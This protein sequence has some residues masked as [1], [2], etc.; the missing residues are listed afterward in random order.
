MNIPAP[1]R[2][3]A[4]RVL[5]SGSARYCNICGRSWRRFLPAGVAARD[6]ARCPGCNSLERH[7]LVW[8]FFERR[9]NLFDRRPKRVLHIAPESCFLPQLRKALGSNYVTADLFDP[10]ADHQWDVT[11]VPQPNESFDVIYCS[12][13]LEHVLEDRKAM[14]E[15]HRLLKPDGWAVINVPVTEESTFEDPSVTDPEERLRLFGQKD[16]VRRYGR[17]YL[18]RLHA[19]GFKVEIV[20]PSEIFSA[21]DI[22]R[23]AVQIETAGDVYHCTK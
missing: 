19:A 18:D 5:L 12:H 11:A 2:R 13:V 21:P 6:D 8:A 17:D 22:V 14:A 23:L 16:H 9:T 20:S 10:T 15:F 4:K 1:I 3:L 7:R